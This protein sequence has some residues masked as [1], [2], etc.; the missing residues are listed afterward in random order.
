[1]LD[2]CPSEQYP[3]CIYLVM[4]PKNA[5]RYKF[6]VWFN[7]HFQFSSNI[8]CWLFGFFLNL[9]L[10]LKV[11]CAFY[12][13]IQFQ[14]GTKRVKQMSF[15]VSRSHFTDKSGEHLLKRSFACIKH[16]RSCKEQMKIH[17]ALAFCFSTQTLT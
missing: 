12:G 17:S 13:K 9:L 11:Q 2:F 8:F 5:Q 14:S 4:S 7:T 3:N 15:F 16:A 6:L 1:M 10:N